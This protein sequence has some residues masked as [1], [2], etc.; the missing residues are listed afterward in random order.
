MPI[1]LRAASSS[2]HPAASHPSLFSLP[3]YRRLW[4]IGGLTGIARWLEFLA[5]S[6]FAFEVTK[7]APMVALLAIMRMLPYVFFGI[8]TGALADMFDR[9]R[10]LLAGLGL[11]LATSL[12]M[13]GL[14]WFELAGYWS[15]VAATL[16]SGFFW[17]TDMPVRRRL[18]VDL[19][20]PA[21]VPAALGYDNSTSYATRALG[22]V[23]GGVA[24]QALGIQG[25]FALSLVIYGVCL[26]LALGISAPKRAA[27][28][29]APAKIPGLGF[30]IPP[31]ELLHNR[32]FLIILG[33]TLVYNVWCF[34]FVTMVPVLAQ[35]DFG[36]S[37]IGVGMLSAC[38]GIGG[39]LG[40]I[41]V[42][43][44]AKEH[45]FFRYYFFGTLVFL[46][47]L[48]LLALHLTVAT[49]TVGLFLIGASAACFSASQYALVYLVS[50]PQLRG[51]AAG[52]LSIFIGSAV[53]GFYNAGALFASYPSAT[54]MSLMAAEGLVPLLV[55]G[56]LW[57]RLPAPP[58]NT[59]R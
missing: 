29:A 58:H 7:S 12:T 10:L 40:A 39:T 25:I 8:A 55:L 19:V 24:Y 57:W 43:R 4:A 27:G 35:K 26:L 33:I 22:P 52:F 21:R 32:A 49:A 37:P 28:E 6:V 11:V 17:V 54:A 48:A 46:I 42:G 47:M 1:P 13:T 51:R 36:L 53:I 16:I 14:A 31:K 59:A 15:V 38:D 2:P 34:P 20:G 45:T 18:L 56:I 50:P 5:L 23:I 9:R 44:L 3:D 41:L 30:I